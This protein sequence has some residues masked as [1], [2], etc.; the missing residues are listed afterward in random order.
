M[1]IRTDDPHHFFHIPD[2]FAAASPPAEKI[3]VIGVTQRVI[4][5]DDL[6]QG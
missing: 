1:Q 2:G 6:Q 3:Q 5:G 4:T